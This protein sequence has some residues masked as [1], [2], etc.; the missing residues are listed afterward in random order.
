MILESG[1]A[2]NCS[3]TTQRGLL[4]FGCSSLAPP[5]LLLARVGG[6]PGLVPGG[7]EVLQGGPRLTLEEARLLEPLDLL[8]EDGSEKGPQVLRH[9]GGVHGDPPG[10]GPRARRD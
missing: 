6:L 9:V 8:V 3:R 2:R 10:R 4:I 1:F 7:E 5:A